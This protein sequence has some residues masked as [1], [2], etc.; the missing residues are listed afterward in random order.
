MVER[1]PKEIK[2]RG[3]VKQNHRDKTRRPMVVTHLHKFYHSL[4][5]AALR[6]NGGVVLSAPTELYGMCK[7]VNLPSNDSASCSKK[8]VTNFVFFVDG[9]VYSF[10]LSCGGEYIG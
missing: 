9:V 3:G 6:V 2:Q 5:R 10:P 1:L 7:K 4:K 8:H